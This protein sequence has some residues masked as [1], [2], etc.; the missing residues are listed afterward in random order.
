MTFRK[1]AKKMPE[2]LSPRG[3]HFGGE[4]RH[5][6]YFG[7]AFCLVVRMLEAFGRP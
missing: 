3:R 4:P 1:Q 6:E 5:R 2:N 7:A